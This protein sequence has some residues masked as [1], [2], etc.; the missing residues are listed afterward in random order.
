MVVSPSKSSYGMN[1]IR[2]LIPYEFGGTVSTCFLPKELNAK[3]T[4]L[5]P[6]LVAA[7]PQ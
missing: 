5:L 2:E 4:F 1:V 7:A 6:G 3:W